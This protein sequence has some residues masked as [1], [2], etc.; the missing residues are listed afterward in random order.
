[1]HGIKDAKAGDV[2][3]GGKENTKW[4]KGSK[5]SNIGIVSIHGDYVYHNGSEGNWTT[6][7]LQDVFKPGEYGGQVWILRP[8]EEIAKTSI[9]KPVPE[10][11]TEE[12]RRTVK[13]EQTRADNLPTDSTWRPDSRR[14]DF[15]D[16]RDSGGNLPP[17]WDNEA[18]R[19]RD[20]Q[21]NPRRN[22]G[23]TPRRDVQVVAHRPGNLNV[24][25]PP[26]ITPQM[27]DRV[28]AEYDSPAQGLGQKVFDLGV[29]HGIN[30]AIA[31]AFFI[32]ESSAG[33]KGVARTTLNWGNRKGEGPA[34]RYRGFMKY[35]SFSDSLEDWFPYIIDKYVNQGRTTLPRVIAKYA[36][37]YDG[38]DERGYVRAVDSLLT[39]WSRSLS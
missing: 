10:Q 28:L 24:M 13:P 26:T 27:I 33:T 2:V 7:Q 18:W 38:N 17:G 22:D 5:N 16:R 20:G 25:G 39:K 37:G 19:E 31:L 3:F 6:S 34:G 35:D 14:Q 11:E 30:P 29:K 8:P 9:A 12:V 4:Q 36:P 1:M 32:K 21:R 15:V 23:Y